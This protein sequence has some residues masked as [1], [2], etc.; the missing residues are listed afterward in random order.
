MLFSSVV[1]PHP[2]GPTIA[3]IRPSGISQLMSFSTGWRLQSTHRFLTAMCG[4]GY[5]T[6]CRVN[7][8][9]IHLEAALIARTISMRTR[10]EA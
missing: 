3:T 5:W 8:R 6:L 9:S 2:D 10:A 7:R 4:M 1:F